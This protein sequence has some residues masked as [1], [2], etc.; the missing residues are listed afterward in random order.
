MTGALGAVAEGLLYFILA[1]G[2]LAFGATEAWSLAVLEIAIFTLFALCATRSPLKF[3]GTANK[4]FLPAGLVLIGLATIQCFSER[5]ISGPASL[6]PFTASLHSTQQSILLGI[7]YIMFLWSIPRV[8]TRAT[9]YDRLPWIL[10]LIG[11]LIAFVGIC[12]QGQG[13][14]AYYGIRK[15]RH[16]G[17]FGPYTNNNHAAS[18]MVMAFSVGLGLFYSRFSTFRRRAKYTAIADFFTSQGLFL[19][20]LAILLFGIIKTGS[21]GGLYSLIF[22]TLLT[23]IFSIGFLPRKYSFPL[24][25]IGLS[26]FL[27]AFVYFIHLNPGIRNIDPIAFDASLRTRISIYMSSFTMIRDFPLW[28][29]G[30]GAFRDSFFP[31]QS[32][33]VYGMVSN[34]HSDLFEIVVETGIIG[35]AASSLSLL[36]FYWISLRRWY[37]SNSHPQKILFFGFFAA[38]FCFLL[39]SLVDFVFHIPA[40]FV[41]FIGLT[42]FLSQKK[43]APALPQKPHSFLNK[44]LSLAICLGL[45][46]FAARPA[47]AS[48]YIRKANKTLPGSQIFYLHK[49]LAWD[50]SRSNEILI[51]RRYIGLGIIN[52][53]AKPV[54]YRQALKSCM[55]ALNDHASNARIRVVISHLLKHLGRPVDAAELPKGK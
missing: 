50:N 30:L 36:S 20:G 35:L 49:A 19:F 6:L 54:F 9:A 43:N 40:N 1:F 25:L 16:G 32:H 37:N 28:G 33:P 15:V 24:C 42:A 22:A 47:I 51:C 48:W 52:P 21:R 34:A 53:E 29:I 39:H 26:G 8:L 14:L 3:F 38:S 44:S 23:G 41:F 11:A 4:I 13:N 2:P 12:Q 17:V 7:A 5:P 31:Y 10:F 45:S 55:N 18:L 27:G 46:F